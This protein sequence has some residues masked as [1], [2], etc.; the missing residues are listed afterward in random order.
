MI[1]FSSTEDTL[2][3]VDSENSSGSVCYILEAKYHPMELGSAAYSRALKSCTESYTELF[4]VPTAFSPN[5]DGVND[6]FE[7]GDHGFE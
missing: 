7:L 1:E 6:L 4:V 5:G 2:S 3:L